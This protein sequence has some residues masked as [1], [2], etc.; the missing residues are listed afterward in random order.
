MGTERLVKLFGV[1]LLGFDESTGKK[2][3]FTLVL[4][5]AYV[6]VRRLL[7]LAS[8]TVLPPTKASRISFWSQQAMSV[9]PFAIFALALVSV[10]F[11]DAN[12][13]ATV[14]GLFTA[15][16]AFALQRVITSFAAY[17]VL[18]RGSTFSVGDRIVMGGV[19][20]DVIA[21]DPFQTT[22]MEMGE[23]P[24][25]QNDPP[26]LW[27][28]GRQFTGRIVS[29]TNGVLFEQPVYNYTRDFPYLWDEIMIPI[30]YDGDDEQAER[31]LLEAARRH[32]VSAD[33]I[34]QDQKIQLEERFGLAMPE[35]AP[36][37]YYTLTDNWIAISLRFLIHAHNARSIKDR[38]QRDILAALRAARIDIASGTY[39]IVQVP[40]I[41]IEQ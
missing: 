19:R 22:I 11:D 7:R 20:G 3:L 1:P 23:A 16:V 9:I 30:A 28:H 24:G 41:K 37:T 33:S 38:M 31:I 27:V 10:W 2:I 18:L 15:G 13:L 8:K 40:P 34:A 6:V 17:L 32:A 25:E 26:S 36:R 12:R 21:L 14:A 4:A 5:V 35:I 39:A 29:V